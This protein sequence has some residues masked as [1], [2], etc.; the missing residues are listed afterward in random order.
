M[1]MI[2]DGHAAFATAATT[3]AAAA[4]AVVATVLSCGHIY[5]PHTQSAKTCSTL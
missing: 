3:A 1:S 2:A 4:A 5:I